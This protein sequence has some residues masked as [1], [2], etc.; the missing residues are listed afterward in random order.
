MWWGEIQ[1]VRMLLIEQILEE[2][3]NMHCAHPALDW[4]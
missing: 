1:V 4:V 2:G 3:V